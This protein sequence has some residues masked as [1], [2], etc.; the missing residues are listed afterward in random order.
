[1]KANYVIFG[2]KVDI[3]DVDLYD[4]KFSRWL[5]DQEYRLCQ[6]SETEGVLGLVLFN[7]RKDLDI[8][9]ELSAPSKEVECQI[10]DD[11]RNLF[12]VEN[13]KDYC[14]L[15]SVTEWSD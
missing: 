13:F 5:I 6:I 12:G 8:C 1:M 7:S 4:E 14:R 15:Y 10:Y 11:I 3:S 2:Y 9:K